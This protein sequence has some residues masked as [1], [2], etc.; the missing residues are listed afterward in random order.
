MR[1]IVI[2]AV[3]AGTLVAA[4]PAAAQ[5]PLTIYSSLPLVGAQGASVEDVLLSE[6]LALEQ[7][8]GRAGQFPVRLVSLNDGTQQ[9]GTWDP[10]RV[11]ANARR[12]AEDPSAIAYVGDFN[13]SASAISLPARWCSIAYSTAPDSRRAAR[14]R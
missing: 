8:G 10:S 6:Q 2:L 12:A 5:Q 1:R 4:A 7:A 9:A 3:V 13:S 11:S 14:P